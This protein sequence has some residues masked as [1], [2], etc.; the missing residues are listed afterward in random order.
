MAGNVNTE[1]G[2]AV[3]VAEVA[4]WKLWNLLEIE[5]LCMVTAIPR[6]DRPKVGRRK[7]LGFSLLLPAVAGSSSAVIHEKIFFFLVA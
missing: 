1:R 3:A 6:Y 2:W 4:W 5:E 7:C